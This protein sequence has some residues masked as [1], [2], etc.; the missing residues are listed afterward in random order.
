MDVGSNTGSGTET[1][2]H[3]QNPPKIRIMDVQEQ[4]VRNHPLPVEA[5][6]RALLFW[7]YTQVSWPRADATAFQTLFLSVPAEIQPV[8]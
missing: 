5:K 2:K 4:E 1:Q 3:A 7:T 6:W 8:L